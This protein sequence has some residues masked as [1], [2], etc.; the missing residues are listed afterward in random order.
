[1]IAMP[2][3]SSKLVNLL[4]KMRVT[5]ARIEDSKI[6]VHLEH[7]PLPISRI[8]VVRSEDLVGSWFKERDRNIIRIDDDLKRKHWILSLAVH[9]VVEK[10]IYETFFNRFPVDKVYPH[11]IHTIAEEI[12]KHFHISR[13]GKES[14]D[15]YNR[16]VDI[17]HLKESLA[18]EE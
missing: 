8:K 4:K 11:P 15:E 16:N 9:E 13:W 12:E 6:V 2:K 1:V 3:I 14:W 17:I 10:W 18:Y 5:S 7:V